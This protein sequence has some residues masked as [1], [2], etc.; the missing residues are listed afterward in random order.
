MGIHAP[1]R[2]HDEYQR[3]VA[4]AVSD[5]LEIK[6]GTVGTDRMNQECDQEGWDGAGAV[7][8]GCCCRPVLRGQAHLPRG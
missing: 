2:N 8:G 4:C 6:Q 5:T 7:G 1:T 3:N